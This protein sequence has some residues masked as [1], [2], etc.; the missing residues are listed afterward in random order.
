MPF[1][2]CQEKAIDSITQ[3]SPAFKIALQDMD[4]HL[5]TIS[6]SASFHGCERIMLSM[7]PLLY[8]SVTLIFR[9]F[10]LHEYCPDNILPSSGVQPTINSLF[11]ILP[12]PS[13][14][15]SHP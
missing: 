15:E 12:N 13:Q 7:F 2:C 5:G 9:I 14:N 11:S 4:S 8:I 1:I 10:T 3:T 6:F